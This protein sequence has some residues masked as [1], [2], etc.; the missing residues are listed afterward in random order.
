MQYRRS[1]TA[2]KWQALKLAGHK[3]ATTVFPLAHTLLEVCAYAYRFPPELAARLAVARRALALVGK[4]FFCETRADVG[5]LAAMA[6][7]LNPELLEACEGL[8]GD[9]PNFR[10]A[11]SPRRPAV[12]PCARPQAWKNIL[13]V[14][15]K[16]IGRAHDLNGLMVDHAHQRFINGAPGLPVPRAPPSTPAAFENSNHKGEEAVQLLAATLRI[17]SLYHYACGGVAT[18]PALRER[19]LATCEVIDARDR[20]F[21]RTPHATAAGKWWWRPYIGVPLLP[22]PLPPRRVAGTQTAATTATCTCRCAA[23]CAPR[24]RAAAGW[25]LARTWAR[26]A[27]CCAAWWRTPPSAS[28]SG[29]CRAPRAPGRRRQLLPAARARPTA[30][31]HPAAADVRV[32]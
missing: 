13:T 21:R 18:D 26:S 28:S 9:T 3:K 24:R 8:G 22:P 7:T 11:P 25:P 20:L 32:R 30:A 2:I 29:A 4:A 31:G 15:L 19:S 5:Q 6:H 17:D 1:L 16:L 12:T 10:V 23:A 27:S 14:D